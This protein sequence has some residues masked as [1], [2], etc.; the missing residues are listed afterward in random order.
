M[1]NRR[2]ADAV[3]T[4]RLWEKVSHEVVDNWEDL[5]VR[6]QNQARDR[7]IKRWRS[8][9]DRFKKKGDA[10]PEWIGRTQEQMQICY[11]PVVPR[12]TVCNTREPAEL[13]PS[14]AIPPESATGDQFDRPDPTAPSLTSGPSV[15][16]TSARAS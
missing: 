8:L 9:R 6:A 10:G 11:S 16:S 2:H 13:N 15:P 1:G 4:Q 5:E 7:V 14:G 12:S 3:V